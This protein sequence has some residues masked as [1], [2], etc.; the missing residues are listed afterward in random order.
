VDYILACPVIDHVPDLIAWLHDLHAALK[1]GGR[2]GLAVPDRRFIFDIRRN[3]SQ[4][5]EMVEAHPLRYRK[6][7]IRQVFG[8][9]ALSTDA[10]ATQAWRG[11]LRDGNVALDW[12]AK[13]PKAFGV[14]GGMIEHPSDIDPDC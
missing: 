4:L 14:A 11:N 8:V 7:S 6:I 3:E 12:L 5:S 9:S 13:L 2:L 10:D 1:P